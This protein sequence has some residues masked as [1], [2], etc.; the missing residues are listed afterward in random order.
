M[1][2]LKKHLFQSKDLRHP[3]DTS[4]DITAENVNFVTNPE[5]V[6]IR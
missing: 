6:Y 5:R 4:M 1:Q 3:D 2:K